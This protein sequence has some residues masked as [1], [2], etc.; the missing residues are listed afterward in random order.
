MDENKKILKSNNNRHSILDEIEKKSDFSTPK[1]YFESLP[2]VTSINI[3]N[4]NKL[5]NNFDILSY[6]VLLPTLMILLLTIFV[7]NWNSDSEKNE[8][9]NEQLSEVL[10]ESDYVDFDDELLYEVYS[11]TLT[12]EEKNNEYID[13]LIE[14][15]VELNTII[16]EL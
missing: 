5:Y 9:T 4:K 12:E 14:N 10:I 3:L 2:E 13:Y 6:R 16:D 7:F 11:E 1:D 8:L 15:N